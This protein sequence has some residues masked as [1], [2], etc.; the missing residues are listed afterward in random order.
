MIAN[1]MGGSVSHRKVIQDYYVDVNN[2]ADILSKLVN[3]YRLLIGGAGELNSIA[4]SKKNDI[5]HALDRANDVGE[6]IDEIIDVLEATGYGY[7][8]YCKIKSDVLKCKIEAQYIQTEID[9]E[10]KLKE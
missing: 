4:L 10:L 8:N 5:K 3:S 2:M 6:I 9:E 1:L 7:L